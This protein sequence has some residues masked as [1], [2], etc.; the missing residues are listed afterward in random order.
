MTPMSRPTT[1]HR[2]LD[3]ATLLASTGWHLEDR[4][5]CRGDR[6][7]PVPPSTLDDTAALAEALGVGVAHD[8]EHDLWAIGPDARTRTIVDATLPDLALSS[9]E[10]D[11]V[12]LRSLI[13]RRGILVAW[14]SW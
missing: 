14:A 5:A 12:G 13:G 9:R 3:T 11:T 1:I 7:V 2:S 6:C 8:D 10:G 4:G